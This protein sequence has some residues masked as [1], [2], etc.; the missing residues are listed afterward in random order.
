MSAAACDV[1]I[2]GAG[3][4]GLAA[5]QALR[6]AGLSVTVL[7]ARGRIGG[8]AYTDTAALG[9]PFD[10]GAQWLHVS[11]VNPLVPLVA[12]YGD[13]MLAHKPRLHY[14]AG[15]RAIDVSD[16][17]RR[18]QAAMQGPADI[19]VAAVFPEACEA[20]RL[21]A[22]LECGLICGTDADRLSALDWA[23][24]IDGE[25]NG[26]LADGLGRFVQRFATEALDGAALHLDCPVR[27][28]EW[29]RPRPRLDTPG[30]AL[31]AGAILLTVS[32]GVL[33]SEAIR[34]DPPLPGW[35]LAALEALPMGNLNKLAFR[36]DMPADGL[37]DDDDI[38]LLRA[39]GHVV[40]CLYRPLGLPCAV[41]YL[42]G[43]IATALEAE[44]HAVMLDYGREI[45]AEALGSAVAGG[46]LATGIASWTRDPW[47]RGAYA[48]ARPGQ[49]QSRAELARPV[50]HRLFFAG[51]A[52]ETVWAAQLAG[53]WRSGRRAAEEIVAARGR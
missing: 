26:L 48:T 28:I 11:D 13:R 46:I 29:D 1:A 50:N 33:A 12:R 49:F 31:E 35:K 8:R 7:E 10:H 2:V 42:G 16:S 39:D 25:A 22:G 5:A 30:G 14:R 18:F 36:L 23:T 53:A 52:T 24:M 51:E 41:V 17:R 37:E 44:G 47:S 15:S 19:A 43:S 20:D 27:R 32:T 9:L 38:V 6:A 45:V 3:M 40:S 21:V 34:F 4:A